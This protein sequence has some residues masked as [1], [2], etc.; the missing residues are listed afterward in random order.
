MPELFIE[1]GSEEIPAGYVQP[2]LEYMGEELAS[3]FGRNRIKAEAPQ[4]MGTPRRLVVSVTGVD[5]L[6]E[7]SVDIFHGPN[8]S[9]AFDEKGEP[10]KAAIGFARGKGLDVSDLTR[11]TTSK[12]E[13]VCARVEKKGRPT[14]EHLNEFLPQFIGN[15]PFPKKMRW[16]SKASPFARPLHW[17]TALF[18]EKPLQFSFDGIE[19]G[20][21]SLGHRFLKPGQFK[22]SNLSSYI[23]QSA[24]HFLM[25]DPELR[26]QKILEQVQNLAEKAG[27]LVENDPDLLD[28]VNFLVEYPV[29]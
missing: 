13:V 25:V 11:E 27:G 5:P 10:T 7:D 22:V 16:A 26:K 12:G 4:I 18:D 8:V 20:D 29:A 28:S 23:E 15:I 14:R 19:S 21:L 17:I 2:A 9:V 3:F 24:N 6:Q 1:I